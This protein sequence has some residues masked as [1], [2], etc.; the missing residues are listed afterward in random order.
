M[1]GAG[2]AGLPQGAEEHLSLPIFCK[3][4]PR[5]VAWQRGTTRYE[6][7][8]L[9]RVSGHGGTMG[10]AVTPAPA[11]LKAG[12]PQGLGG[13]NPP[14]LFSVAQGTTCVVGPI[15]SPET[16]TRVPG[17]IDGRPGRLLHS[18]NLARVWPECAT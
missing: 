2:G 16:V 8:R 7:T 10:D 13:S 3:S 5:H 14:L 18:G 1:Q 4:T 11:H 15:R 17:A 6:P 9:G 12:S